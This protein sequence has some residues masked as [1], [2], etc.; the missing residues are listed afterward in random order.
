MFH[1]FKKVCIFD[2]VSVTKTRM[3]LCSRKTTT[4]W[5]HEKSTISFN[6]FER[7]TAAHCTTTIPVYTTFLWLDVITSFF[8]YRNRNCMPW[9]YKSFSPFSANS[10]FRGNP[11]PK[12]LH[13]ILIVLGWQFSLLFFHW[14]L[15]RI[16]KISTL[17]FTWNIEFFPP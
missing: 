14:K 3:F 13:K 17:Y 6:L 9:I 4:N 1:R 7:L 8:Y 10:T 11:Q 15:C 2:H 16:P 12:Y 5:R